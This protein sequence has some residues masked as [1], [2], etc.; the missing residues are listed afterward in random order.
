MRTI[1]LMTGI[2]AATMW[3]FVAR[4]DPLPFPNGRYVTDNSLCDMSEEDMAIRH[5]DTI[6]SMVRIINGDRVFDGGEMFCTV[7]NVRTE[8]NNVLFRARCSAEGQAQTV[9]GRYVRLSPTSFGL[10]RETFNL[11]SSNA[12]ATTSAPIHMEAPAVSELSDRWYGSEYQNCDGS[13]VD[14]IECVNGLRDKWDDRL[15][16]AYRQ[17]MEAES[18]SRKTALRNA[19]RQWIAYRDANCAYYAGGQGSIAGIETAVCQYAL[20]RDRA[21]ELEM[22]VGGRSE[23]R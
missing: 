23:T 11:C 16:A 17:I 14:M 7:S 5:G 10:G 15:N 22:M 8:G 12:R 18:S 19:Q 3:T 13:T 2:V 20:T 9:N 21:Q 4:A 6:G 1:Y